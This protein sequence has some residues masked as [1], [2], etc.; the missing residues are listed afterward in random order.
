MRRPTLRPALLGLAAFAALACVPAV[1]PGFMVFQASIALTYAI[2]IL[3]LNLLMGFNGQVSLAQGVFFAIGGYVV[4]ILMVDYAVPVWLALAAAVAGNAILGALVGIPALRLQGLQLA[5]L[6][7]V[8]AALVPP[9]VM[10]FDK[11]T[12]GT[13]G[14]SIDKP[15]PPAWL[16]LD[17]DSFVYFLCLAGAGL[18]VLV[19]SQLIHGETGRMLRAVRDNPVIAESFGV[20]VARTRIATFATS[21]A[22]GGFAGGLFALVNAFVSP[23]SFQ[24]FKSFEF[25]A[26]AIIGGITSMTGAFIGAVIVV[27]LPEWSSHISLAMAGLIYG[28]T[29]VVMMLVA[30]EGVAGLIGKTLSRAGAASLSMA[31][32]TK[33]HPKPETRTMVLAEKE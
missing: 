10:R 33:P 22:F 29:L 2:A 21:A 6:T 9:L 4:A 20:H 5:I 31:S 17:Q 19:M 30:R 13:S 23:D 27:F 3:G 14:I 18:C 24:L 1:L 8:L 7:L 25:L 12:K 15:E 11:I 26:G 32:Q 28:G 16:P